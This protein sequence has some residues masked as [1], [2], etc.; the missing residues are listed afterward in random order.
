MS[1]LEVNL[2]SDLWWPIQIF[3]DC[4]KSG[5]SEDIS[6]VFRWESG[7]ERCNIAWNINDRRNVSL[8]IKDLLEYILLNQA[9]W[10]SLL[11]ISYDLSPLPFP[12]LPA[13]GCVYFLE[14]CVN[15]RTYMRAYIRGPHVH[16]IADVL[17]LDSRR[18]PLH[19]DDGMNGEC[20]L[21]IRMSY[22]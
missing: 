12:L 4:R 16:E 1:V 6:E 17:L 5:I 8:E 18:L 21:S 7:T 11:H 13:P 14:E 19:R 2:K 9:P 3:R 10:K 20:S 22:P 15:T